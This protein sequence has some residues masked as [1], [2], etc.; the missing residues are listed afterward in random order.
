MKR[1]AGARHEIDEIRR[2]LASGRI[3][4]GSRMPSPADMA[5]RINSTSETIAAAYA[6]LFSRDELTGVFYPDIAANLFAG[7]WKELSAPSFEQLA[8]L[9]RALGNLYSFRS[10]EPELP[11]HMKIVEH[12][13][14]AAQASQQHTHD[15]HELV[16]VTQGA[17]MHLHGEST[18][19]IYNGDCFIVSPGERHG[20]QSSGPMEIVN[21][22][23]YEDCLA[24]HAT[25]LG[26]MPGF[27]SFFSIEPLFRRETSFRH[28]L[29][30]NVSRLRT[31]LE[32]CERIRTELSRN[33]AGCRMAALANF[34][35]LVVQVSRWFGDSTHTVQALSDLAGKQRVVSEAVALL[36]ANSA[37]GVSVPELARQLFLS[38]SRLQ[39]LFKETTGL[40]LL[41]Y[42]L[43]VRIEHACTL[44]RESRMPIT[45]VAARVGFH[46]RAY[47]ARQFRKKTGVT[48]LRYRTQS[49]PARG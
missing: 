10:E 8:E 42:L 38:Q 16:L 4:K 3:A 44:L 49:L 24:P 31:A 35:Q 30:L 6:Q 15:F 47:F 23:F 22:V 40:S 36:E 2:L 39:H 20:Y 46:D 12:R 27:A 29:H 7:S 32:F 41:E 1:S 21:I 14:T 9:A 37:K 5:R 33:A 18:Y 25:L 34:Y 28:K 11:L 13:L 26:E 48:P 17:G 43:H 19:P 45:H